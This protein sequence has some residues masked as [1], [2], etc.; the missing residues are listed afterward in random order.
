M[1]RHPSRGSSRQLRALLCSFGRR[2][3]PFPSSSLPGCRSSSRLQLD[4]GC[5]LLTATTNFRGWPAMVITGDHCEAKL[6]LLLLSLPPEYWSERSLLI[7]NRRKYRSLRYITGNTAFPAGAIMRQ[8]GVHYFAVV[9]APQS[10][11]SER[12]IVIAGRNFALRRARARRLG[13]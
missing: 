3:H 5:C 1:Y 12:E 8:F 13:Y 11:L 10:V 6:A 2:T 4:M 9:L 7:T